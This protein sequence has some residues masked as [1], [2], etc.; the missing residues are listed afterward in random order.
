MSQDQIVDDIP[1]G[2][3]RAA[4]LALLGVVG[5]FVFLAVVVPLINAHGGS[6][7]TLI[8]VV[9]GAILS[10]FLLPV[11]L[12]ILLKVF[13]LKGKKPKQLLEGFVGYMPSD[14]PPDA[15]LLQPTMFLSSSDTDTTDRGRELVPYSSD[16]PLSGF[17]DEE[18]GEE[19]YCDDLSGEEGEDNISEQLDILIEENGLLLTDTFRPAPGT[20]TCQNV[21]FVGVRRFGKSN[22]LAILLRALA[23]VSVPR[24]EKVGF[25]LVIFDTEDEYEE[26]ARKRYMPRGVLVGSEDSRA[27]APKGIQFYAIDTA[28]AYNFSQQVLAECLQVV[29]NLKAWSD[30]EAAEIM[31]EMILGMED[32]QQHRPIGKRIPFYITIDEITKWVPQNLGE[33]TLSR[34][35]IKLVQYALFDVTVRRGGKRGFGLLVAGQKY[36]DI[37]KRIIQGTW[38]IIFCQ[39]EKN[40]LD[41]CKVSPLNLDPDEVCSLQPGESFV[42]CPQVPSGIYVKWPLSDVPLGGKSPG[43]ENLFAHHQTVQRSVEDVLAS[44]Q[45]PESAMKQQP[46]T[47]PLLPVVSAAAVPVPQVGEQPVLEIDL[48]HAARLWK[49]GHGSYRSLARALGVTPYRAGEIYKAMVEAGLIEEKP[50][51]KVRVKR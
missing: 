47:V 18:Y 50:V 38:K 14:M 35:A 49:A 4:I 41:R 23:N 33:S 15:G 42:F 1:K 9:F 28:T 25:P 45:S 16:S 43:I 21:T 39:T 32:W 31:S 13:H 40:D 2:S 5:F 36:A 26:L 27:D 6:T 10:A 22:A 30:N 17:G 7:D 19:E 8:F 46:L 20:L 44:L 34:D 24:L 51:V 11:L 48:Q 12:N 37:D 3:P 29:V